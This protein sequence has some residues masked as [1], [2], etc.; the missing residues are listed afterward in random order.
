MEI[1]GNL[2]ELCGAI[3]KFSVIAFFNELLT[4]VIGHSHFDVSFF[5]HL[6]CLS[7]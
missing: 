2:P 7:E 4:K 5:T 6:F 3:L 1:A